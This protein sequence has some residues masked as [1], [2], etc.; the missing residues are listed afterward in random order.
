MTTIVQ[1]AWEG[2]MANHSTRRGKSRVRANPSHHHH[3]LP[4]VTSPN[5]R[6]REAPS[7]PWLGR[8]EE[9][10]AT[11]IERGA[12]AGRWLRFSF[13]PFFRLAETHKV[14]PRGLGSAQVPHLSW[15]PWITMVKIILK[16]W[17]SL[18]HHVC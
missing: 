16:I 8:E 12:G 17:F 10:T 18:I 7:A 9:A 2:T 15:A 13:F 6:E 4:L 14:S 11:R 3:P 5:D 1:V